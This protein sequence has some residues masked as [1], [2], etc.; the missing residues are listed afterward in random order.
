MRESTAITIDNIAKNCDT[1]G[2]EILTNIKQ[3]RFDVKIA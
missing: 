2:Y 1:I 3:N